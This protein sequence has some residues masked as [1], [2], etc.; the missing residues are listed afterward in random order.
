MTDATVD[1]FIREDPLVWKWQ[2]EDGSESAEWEI[3]PLTVVGILPD[4]GRGIDQLP[5]AGWFRSIKGRL[6]D[7]SSNQ[8][9]IIYGFTFNTTERRIVGKQIGT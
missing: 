3:D 7:D 1:Y 8:D 4:T 6:T 9:N 2:Y 5:P